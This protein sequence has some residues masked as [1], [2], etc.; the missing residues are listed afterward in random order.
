M[1]QIKARLLTAYVWDCDDCGAENF[2]RSIIAELHD[3]EREEMY[4]HFHELDEWAELPEHWREFQM[5]TR[6]DSV[7]C[8]ECG[9][10]FDATD[11]NEPLE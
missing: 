7:T 6:P 11:D 4:R 8:C 10:V 5:V 3:D 2:E 1:E 9:M